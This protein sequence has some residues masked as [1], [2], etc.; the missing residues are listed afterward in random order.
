MD[1][2]HLD[3]MFVMFPP[4]YMGAEIPSNNDDCPGMFGTSGCSKV[5][6]FGIG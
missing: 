1:F 5:A 2:V 4:A 6:G 3:D